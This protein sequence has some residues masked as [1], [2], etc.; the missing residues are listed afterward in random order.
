MI[1]PSKACRWG[2]VALVVG[3]AGSGCSTVA[4]LRLDADD[5]AVDEVWV[6][7]SGEDLDRASGAAA[8]IRQ[9]SL[10]ARAELDLGSVVEGRAAAL[11]RC[12]DDGSWLAAR[13]DASTERARD[14]LR[15]ARHEAAGDPAWELERARRA[16]DVESRAAQARALVGRTPGGAEALALAAESLVA[17]GLVDEAVRLLGDDGERTGRL[18]AVTRQVQ[19][20][21][22]ARLAA[23]DGVLRDVDEGLA[24]PTSLVVLEL[25]TVEL[26]LAGVD[27]AIRTALAA[28]LP[29]ELL[30]RGRQRVLARLDA[31]AGRPLVAAERLA[32]REDLLPSESLAVDAWRLRG[33][34][35]EPRE[36]AVDPSWPPERRVDL[37]PRRVESHE[38]ARL[39]RLA[40][41]DL[42]AREHYTG[43]LEGED[44]LD[45]PELLEAL[46]AVAGPLGVPPTRLVEA[47]R[48]DYGVLGTLV[49][50]EALLATDPGSF[51]LAGR[52]LGLPAEITA[53]DVEACM[54]ADLAAHGSDYTECL[55]RRLRVPGFLAS[56]GAR[57]TGV[58]L[59]RIVF[60]DLD[61]VDLRVA[62]TRAADPP[63]ALEARP[64]AGR[65]ERRDLSEPLNQAARLEWTA[66][67]SAP[68][69]Y[70]SAVLGSLAA[71]ERQ[72]VD[73]ARTFLT[74][75]WMGRL[76]AV[77]GAGLSP[78]AVRAEL[79]RRAQLAALRE[80]PDPRLPLALAV[81]A[82]PVEGARRADEHAVGY[83]ALLEAFVTV[84]DEGEVVDPEAHGITRT[85][86]LVQQLERLPPDAIRAIARAID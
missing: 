18:R 24:V 30:E 80:A 50:S 46:D 47:P 13:Y 22:G 34:S 1:A 14:R 86:V 5:R 77:A 48:R 82:L 9:P 20:L 67:T 56:Q 60:L 79:E 28:P 69:S 37:D 40:E 81:S 15:A 4:P 72:H 65:V 36:R 68:D 19:W 2:T 83:E 66:S 29:G 63:V 27:E 49:D 25:A 58:G 12:L 31:V 71:H 85:R 17:L 52:G 39:R 51:V 35:E 42:V 57:F 78:R 16:A 23:A 11:V 61:E 43:V 6:A 32:T 73:D 84:L 53:Y 26:P 33:A 45:L 21:S 7:L 76:A 3:L 10:R 55:V 38:M 75:G 41:W 44:E 54:L 74:Q 59:D 64:A 70:R 8:A 62:G